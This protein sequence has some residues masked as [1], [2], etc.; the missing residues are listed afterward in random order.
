VSNKI[1]LLVNSCWIITSESWTYHIVCNCGRKND[2]L[3]QIVQ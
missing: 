1:S 2:P 3:T